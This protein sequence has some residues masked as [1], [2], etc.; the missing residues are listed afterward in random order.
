MR[1]IHGIM[2]APGSD[3]PM[4]EIRYKCKCMRE[5]AIVQVNHRGKNEDILNWMKNVVTKAIFLDH[6]IQSPYCT[7]KN[8]EYVKIHVPPGS[9]FVGAKESVH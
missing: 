4:V 2:Q 7:A 8:T 6:K 3:F 5:E 1:S 9:E